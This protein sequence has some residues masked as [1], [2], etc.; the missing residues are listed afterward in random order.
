MKILL[1]LL[2]T[3]PLLSCTATKVEKSPLNFNG[4]SAI[5]VRALWQLCYQAHAQ[6]VKP[7]NPVYFSLQ[8]DCV[9]D[10][11]MRDHHADDIDKTA[12]L[13]KYFTDTN[14]ECSKKVKLKYFNHHTQPQLNV[15]DVL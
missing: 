2:L 9:V 14:L 6:N 10:K 13:Q 8:C 5:K 7:H 15:G 11:T 12:N 4:Y 1:V 3:I